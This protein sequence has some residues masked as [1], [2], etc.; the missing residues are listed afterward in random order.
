MKFEYDS[1]KSATNKVK[2]GI[3]F[4]EIQVL[5]ES[6]C[7]EIAVDGGTEPRFLVIGVLEGRFYTCVCTMRGEVIRLISARRSRKQEKGMYDDLIKR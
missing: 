5:W 7:I 3:S 4:E 1:N 6:P 2:H